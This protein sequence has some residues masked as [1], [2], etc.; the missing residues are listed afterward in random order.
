MIEGNGNDECR[1]APDQRNAKE[2]GVFS[3]LQTVDK[4]LEHPRHRRLRRRKNGKADD[5]DGEG[6]PV[7]FHIGQKTQVDARA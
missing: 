7:G 6:F 2:Q 3:T 4:V 1:K 5:A